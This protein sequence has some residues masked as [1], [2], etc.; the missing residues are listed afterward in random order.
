MAS[1]GVED[2]QPRRWLVDQSVPHLWADE[3][4]R[5]IG[6]QDR[7]QNPGFQPGKLKTQNLC[8]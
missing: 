1:G 3:L 2:T 8:M 5:T 7:L 4:G 6:K